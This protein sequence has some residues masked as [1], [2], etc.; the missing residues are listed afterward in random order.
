MNSRTPCLDKCRRG[1]EEREKFPLQ[2]GAYKL[3]EVRNRL[4]SNR[5]PLTELM[6]SSAWTRPP[7][8]VKGILT[9]IAWDIGHNVVPSIAALTGDD[10]PM[11]DVAEMLNDVRPQAAE[12]VRRCDIAVNSLATIRGRY[13]PVLLQDVMLDRLLQDALDLI[14]PATELAWQATDAVRHLD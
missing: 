7:P 5:R 8:E 10:V 2:M 12:I 11:S 13:A 14:A 4:E 3:K 1:V 6:T 9:T